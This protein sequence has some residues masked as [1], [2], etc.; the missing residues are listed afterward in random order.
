MRSLA[1]FFLLN[2]IASVGCGPSPCRS[3]GRNTVTGIATATSSTERCRADVEGVV[4]DVGGHAVV[5]V[6]CAVPSASDPRARP[7]R[8]LGIELS[9][10]R[11][12]TAMSPVKATMTTTSGYSTVSGPIEVRLALLEAT[13]YKAPLP[14][15]AT[16][17][18]VRRVLVRL[19]AS[20]AADVDVQLSIRANDLRESERSCP[21]DWGL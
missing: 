11:T 10:P 8:E 4:D 3:T 9:D 20:G 16:D 14:A 17:D 5:N 18:F 12:L 7:S 13:G 6:W 2:A 15:A 21:S 19:R 1:V